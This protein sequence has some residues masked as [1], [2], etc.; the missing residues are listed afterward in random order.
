MIQSV[1]RALQMLWLI[2]DEP[3]ITL[4]EIARRCGLLRSTALRL[5]AT[6]EVHGLIAK[7]PE[8]KSYRLGPAIRTLVSKGRDRV[9]IATRVESIVRRLALSTNE[10]ASFAILDFGLVVHLVAY[11]GASE[12]G[13]Q[14]VLTRPADGRKDN[15]NST[16]VGKIILAFSPREVSDALIAQLPL[17]ATARRTITSIDDLRTELRSVLRRGYATSIDEMSDEVRGLA[18]PVFDNSEELVGAIAV[19]GPAYRFGNTTMRQLVPTVIAAA[20]QASERF[21]GNDQR[22]TRAR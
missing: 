13:S 1:D 7:A 15:L 6:L 10:H 3:G 4:S 16:A 8:T 12:A 14:V 2:R 5:L 21:G 18:A 9:G 19:Y 20:H 22:G 11:D 17:T